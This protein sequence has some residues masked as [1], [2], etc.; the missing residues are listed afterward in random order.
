MYLSSAED[1]FAPR[2]DER[3]ADIFTAMG[4]TSPAVHRTESVR[5]EFARLREIRKE[6]TQRREAAARAAR[7]ARRPHVRWRELAEAAKTRLDDLAFAFRDHVADSKMARLTLAC[8]DLSEKRYQSAMARFDRV[9]ADD[10]RCVEALDGKAQALIGLKRFEEAVETYAQVVEIA[11]S[12]VRA[13]YNYGALLY[14]LGSFGEA[15]WQFRVLLEYDRDHARAHYN[16]AT[17]AQ[18]AGRLGEAM[19]EWERFTLLEPDVAEAWFNLGI[20]YM[21]Y[22][23]PIEAMTCFEQVVEINPDD[24]D[25]RLNLGL[26]LAAAGEL[27]AALRA[28]EAAQDLSPCDPVVLALL[29][30]VHDVLAETAEADA[31]REALRSRAAELRAQAELETTARHALAASNTPDSD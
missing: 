26:A 13:R 17:L 21:D 27:R 3:P 1:E 25:G 16:L 2:D 14:R 29:A 20:I 5:D 4:E 30:D 28:M 6:D 31:E 11:P 19:D 24:V 22:D 12:N 23:R 10:A 9:L 7:R 15:T 18:R 8:A